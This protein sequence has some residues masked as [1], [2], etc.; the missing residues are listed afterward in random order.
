MPAS[1]TIPPALLKTIQPDVDAVHHVRSLHDRA[2][3]LNQLGHRLD[4]VEQ[5]AERMNVDQH[6]VEQVADF[7]CLELSFMQ[8]VS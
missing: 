7:L 8:G 1:L 4:H 3:F 2:E 5:V 6:R